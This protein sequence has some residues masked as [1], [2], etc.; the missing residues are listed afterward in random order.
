RCSHIIITTTLG[1]NFTEPIRMIPDK[2]WDEFKMILPKEKPSK[3]VGRPIVPYRKV[4]DGIVYILRTG[5]QWKMLPRE[6]GSGSVCHRRFQEWNKLDVFKKIW[7]KL[8]KIYDEKV[9][10]INWTWQ[11]I[12]SISIKSPLGGDKTAGNNNPTTDDRSKLGTKRPILT[13][14][15]GIPLSAVI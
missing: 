15:K 6:Y 12:D 3:T 14:K 7:I 1:L 5:C 10:I 4:L 11:S 9:G 2:L 8:L 13:E